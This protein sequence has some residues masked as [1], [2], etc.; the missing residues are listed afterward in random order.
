MTEALLRE[1]R[2]PLPDTSGPVALTS[3]Y[4]QLFGLLIDSPNVDA[5]LDEIV[6]LAAEVVTPAAACGMTVRR[7]GQPF[8]VSNSDDLAAQVDE[9]QYG[10]GEGPCLDAL[11]EGI[12]VQVDDLTQDE[13]WDGYRP[14]AIAHGVVSS[15][16]LPLAVGSQ[17]VAAL[18]LYSGQR[19]AFNG[20]D[21]Q[22]AEAFAAQCAAALVL[23]L[24]QAHQAQVQ[25]QLGEAM[26]SRSIIDQAIGILMG[27]QR[28]NATAAF[29]LLRQASQHRNRKL[30]DIAA[31]IITN[32]TSEPPQ[33][34]TDFKT[35]TDP[36]I[37]GRDEY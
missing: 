19:A 30:R 16:S 23:T 8:T 24:R 36:H 28:C 20:L 31:D 7:N 37:T 18:N 6:R 21:R 17:T 1:S 4:G 13:R 10:A 32:I 14:H 34:P 27:Q 15:L 29:D 35:T 3:A 5:F 22:H 33:P 9:I 25:Q 11:R 2:H 26:A 12:V